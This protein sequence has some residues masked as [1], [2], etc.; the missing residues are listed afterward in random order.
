[1][2]KQAEIEPAEP[3][4]SGKQ[5]GI[6]GGIIAAIILV[7]LIIANIQEPPSRV[8]TPTGKLETSTAAVIQSTLNVYYVDKGYYP[9]SY[10]SL[11]EYKPENEAKL[12]EYKEELR[13]FKYSRRGDEQAYQITYTNIDDKKITLSGNYKEDYR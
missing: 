7:I 13:D 8:D 6:V 12:N 3:Q 5:I 11:I 2:A 10:E 1:M 4:L 9:S